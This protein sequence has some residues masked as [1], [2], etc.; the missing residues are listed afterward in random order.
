[1]AAGTA[2]DPSA[3]GGQVAQ[4]PALTS[5]RFF[6]AF[7]VLAL[8]YRDL[9]GPHGAQIVDQMRG[10]KGKRAIRE[11]IDPYLG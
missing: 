11:T 9:L 6:A 8:H 3:A 10:A 1:M 5:L 4:L 7:A 2:A